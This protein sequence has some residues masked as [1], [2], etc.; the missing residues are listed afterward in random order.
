MRLSATTLSFGAVLLSLSI[1][2][3]SAQVCKENERVGEYRCNEQGD[4]SICHPC[5]YDL[6]SRAGFT[7]CS[8]PCEAGEGLYDFDEYGSFNGNGNFDGCK[9]CETGFYSPGVN[10]PCTACPDGETSDAGS[11]SA[12]DCRRA[13][14]T[15]PVS[16]NPGAGHKDLPYICVNCDPGTF[17]AGGLDAICTSC[18][19]GQTANGYVR[20]CRWSIGIEYSD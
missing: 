3:V 7:Y 17:S 14:D 15:T 4:C 10:A 18:D 2:S 5:E 11:S 16:C 1:S 8:V 19:V 6:V 20:A 12:G 9:Q 13:L